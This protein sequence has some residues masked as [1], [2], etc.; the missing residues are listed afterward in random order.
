MILLNQIEEPIWDETSELGL[1]PTTTEHLL[2]GRLVCTV[3]HE[4]LVEWS[5]WDCAAACAVTLAQQDVS[6]NT[7]E[8]PSTALV[9]E[10]A[11]ACMLMHA[12]VGG[13]LKPTWHVGQ[14]TD[15]QHALPD[16]NWILNADC[17]VVAVHTG[18]P[19]HAEEVGVQAIMLVRQ[20]GGWFGFVPVWVL[21]VMCG[22][23][24]H[25]WR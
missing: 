19:Q 4:P 1:G 23:V 16:A 11:F 10:H 18:L 25:T 24:R 7:E 12:M 21:A 15:K 17:H 8:Q 6:V 13:A 14:L 22:S 20:I 9:W 2:T 5:A 3:A